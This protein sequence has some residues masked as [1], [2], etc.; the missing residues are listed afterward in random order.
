MRTTLKIAMVFLLTIGMTTMIGCE[1][2]E[3]TAPSVTTIGASNV[4]AHTATITG[5]VTSD[6]GADILERG[7]CYSDVNLTPTIIDNKTTE[8]LGIGTFSSILSGLMANKVF[9]ARAYA[10]N[11]KGTSYGVV[12]QFTTVN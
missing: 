4:S 5:E 11:E 6:G 2:D 12:I 8:G 7:I 9:Y 1:D 10:T 3:P